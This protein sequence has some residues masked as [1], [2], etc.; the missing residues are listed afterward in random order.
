MVVII[1][2]KI[3]DLNEISL[4]SMIFLTIVYLIAIIVMLNSKS[5]LESYFLRLPVFGVVLTFV[6]IETIVAFSFIM[7]KIDSITMVF[8]VQFVILALLFIG[9]LKTNVAVN[10]VEKAE[11]NVKYRKE[12]ILDATTAIENVK[13]YT[14]DY[15]LKKQINSLC[16]EMKYSIPKESSKLEDIQYEIMS[17]INALKLAT[18]ENNVKLANDIII[19]IKNL[20]KERNNL[21]KNI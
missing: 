3:D 1:A 12:F 11:R 4:I 17:Q 2:L 14:S 18:K 15:E 6:S 19:D 13:V 5:D 9:I 8:L 21:C 16:E 10:Q 20:I 7:S